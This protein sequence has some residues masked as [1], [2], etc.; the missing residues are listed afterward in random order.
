MS[1]RHLINQANIHHGTKFPICQ[2]NSETSFVTAWELFTLD[3]L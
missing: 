1:Q 2:E 3:L